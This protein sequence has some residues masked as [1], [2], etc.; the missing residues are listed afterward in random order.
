MRILRAPQRLHLDP[1]LFC[2]EYFRGL[3][4]SP[5]RVPAVLKFTIETGET[6]LKQP[7]IPPE[8]CW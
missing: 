8:E 7:K 4:A 6:W 5:R 1:G 3:P 2:A